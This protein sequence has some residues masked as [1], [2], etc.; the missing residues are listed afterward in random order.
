MRQPIQPPGR[1]G[2]HLHQESEAVLH[3]EQQAHFG[4]SSLC[5]ILS[6]VVRHH[7]YPPASRHVRPQV[8]GEVPLQEVEVGLTRLGA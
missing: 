2:H 5:R 6:S 4:L 3:Q 8:S 7:E 1:D